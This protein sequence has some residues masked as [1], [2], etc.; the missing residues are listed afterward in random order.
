MRRI[1]ALGAIL[2]ALSALPLG[3]MDLESLS[4]RDSALSIGSTLAESS[5]PSPLVNSL[6]ISFDFA[7]DGGLYFA[8]SLDFYFWYY[9]WSEALGRPFPAENDLRETI[10]YELQLDAALAYR[11]PITDRLSATAG[12]GIIL[13]LPIVI[14]VIDPANTVAAGHASSTF[15]WFYD[16]LR[17]VRPEASASIRYRLNDT[18]EV[19]AWT[20]IVLPLYHLWDNWSISFLEDFKFNVGIVITYRLGV[21]VVTKTVDARSVAAEA[22]KAAGVT[23]SSFGDSPATGGTTDGSAAPSGTDSG[24]TTPPDTPASGTP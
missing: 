5:A 6:G 4:I 3:A 8:P 20:R 7:L 23:E 18:F 24:G 11:F 9:G 14:E 13:D 10:V 21:A 15:A 16:M 17:F 12:F 22:V 19:G 2:A 1:A